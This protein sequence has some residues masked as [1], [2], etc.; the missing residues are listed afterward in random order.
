MYQKMIIAPSR[1][2]F[3]PFLARIK[4]YGTQNVFVLSGKS[5]RLANRP[6]AT[7]L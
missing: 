4:T 3:C 6:G 7:N 2:E 5:D 1:A